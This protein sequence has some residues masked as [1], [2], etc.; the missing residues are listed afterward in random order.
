[1]A[2]RAIPI[3]RD[4]MRAY[5]DGIERRQPKLAALIRSWERRMYRD[6]HSPSPDARPNRRGLRTLSDDQV[7]AL[8]HYKL[9]NP[10]VEHRKIGELFGVDGGRVSDAMGST[11]SARLDALRDEVAKER[12]AARWGYDKRGPV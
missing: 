6:G 11:R 12:G 10:G 2:T 5:A 8:I 1:M 3:L 7:K 4:E 9:D